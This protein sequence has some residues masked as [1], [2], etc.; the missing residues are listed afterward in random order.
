M[1]AGSSRPAGLYRRVLA[2]E[3]SCDDTS[4]AV[5]EPDGNVLACLMAGQDLHHARFGG[6]VPEIASRNHTHHLLPLI[7]ETLARA[8]VTLDQI[9][10]F[11][12]TSRPGLIGALLIGLVTAKSLSLTTGKPFIGINHL[13]GHLIAPFLR[14]E[15]YQPPV[16]FDFPYV[17]LAVSGGH[18][19]LYR[20]DGFGKYRVLGRTLDDAAG[21]AF[22][23]FAKKAGLGFPGGAR[24]DR[25]ATVGDPKRF[26]F[27][28]A[29]LRNESDDMSFSGLKTNAA[30]VIS[31]LMPEIQ[32]ELAKEA[33][34]FL[35]SGSLKPVPGI[36]ADLCASFQEAVT[37]V[38]VQ[39]LSRAAIREDV[40]RVV[41]TGGVA[42]NSRLRARVEEWAKSTNRI[43]A[44]PP[45]RFCTDN[46]AMIG[47]AGSVRLNSGE[48]STQSLG[49]EPKAP[50]DQESLRTA[51]N[52]GRA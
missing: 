42:A 31:G 26:D 21:E 47:Y 48:F 7:E 17:A 24:V 14:D 10:G 1:P 30:N 22:D 46:A 5:V 16:G 51:T 27:P 20:V 6:I 41:L 8:G 36:L 11:A 43:A 39:R 34:D 18:T 40:S 28:R 23:K 38:L 37:D 3:T 33:K 15:T 45:M 25:L 9:D 44:I 12:V 13:E 29:M 52:A 35:A 32:V 4:V 2:I 19:T 50:L 49:P